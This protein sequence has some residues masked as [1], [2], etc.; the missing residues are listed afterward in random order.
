MPQKAY[1]QMAADLLALNSVRQRFDHHQARNVMIDEPSGRFGL[2][3]VAPGERV[4]TLASLVA[5][6]LDTN[7]AYRMTT[8]HSDLNAA[9][10]TILERCIRAA[11]RK[12]LPLPEVNHAPIPYVGHGRIEYS[13]VLAGETGA[14][15]EVRADLMQSRAKKAVGKGEGRAWPGWNGW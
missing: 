10:R 15:Q 14:W 2:V 6:L 9:R 4:N 13:F 1:D 11:Q 12:Q 7:Y 8:T 3:D 5:P